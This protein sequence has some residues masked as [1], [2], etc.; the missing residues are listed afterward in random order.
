MRIW[1]LQAFHQQEFVMDQKQAADST[2]VDKGVD[3]ASKKWFREANFGMMAH[4]GLYTLL[5]G[6]WKGRSGE[7]PYGEW[8]MN[9]CRIPLKEYAELAKAF[10]PIFFDP[11]EWMKRARDAGMRYFVITSKHHDGFAMY[12]SQVSKF[13][14]VDATPFGRDAIAEIAEACRETGV[15]LG[16][17]YSQDVDWSDPD[18]GGEKNE[19][20][21]R[22]WG[23]KN[24]RNNWDWPDDGAVDFSRYFERKCKPQVK[25]ILTQYGD[26]CLIWFDVPCTISREQCHELRDMVRHYQPGCLINGRLGYGIGDYH[27]PGDNQIATN[28]DPDALYETVGTMNDSWGYRPT[29]TNYKSVEEILAI[30]ARCESIGSNYMLNIG[31]DP[32]GRIPADGIRILDGL[33]AAC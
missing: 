32:L 20:G 24:W 25:E 2:S 15:R 18:G 14:I 31:P 3:P 21:R 17:Y 13:N 5:G 33:A 19:E 26:L 1:Y 8:I 7:H 28:P 29:D 12:R 10:S 16:L 4:W 6:E 23:P 9:S 22:V 11:L 30:K 27:T